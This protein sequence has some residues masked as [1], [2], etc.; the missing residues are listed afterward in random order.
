MIV[1]LD[2]IV[3]EII[4]SI[5][6]N[7]KLLCSY[8]KERLRYRRLRRNSRRA[9]ASLMVNPIRRHLD[10]QGIGRSLLMV[11][12]LPEGALAQRSNSI[13]IAS[14]GIPAQCNI[15]G[16]TNCRHLT[17]TASDLVGISHYHSPD[18]YISS[19]FR[20]EPQMS[21]MYA[22]PAD[23]ERV[24]AEADRVNNVISETLELEGFNEEL[25][26]DTNSAHRDDYFTRISDAF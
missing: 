21:Y 1:C 15:C 14:E 2:I 24:L 13:S 10:Y 5:I 17:G 18:I 9:L 16:E 12:E 26:R 8:I 6:K 7:F 4:S 20:E 11:D 19:A 3:D 25:D 23:M 22:P